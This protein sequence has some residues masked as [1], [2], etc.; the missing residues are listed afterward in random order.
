MGVTGRT[1]RGAETRGAANRHRFMRGS[2]P[3]PS[4]THPSRALPRDPWDPSMRLHAFKRIAV[5]LASA[6]TIASCDD[7]GL[8]PLP[9]TSIP[10]GS[11]Q[12]FLNTVNDSVL[13]STVSTRIVGVAQERSVADSG[14][15]SVNVDGSYEQRYWLRHFIT[16][17]LDRSETVIDVGTWTTTDSG[18]VFTSTV[19]TRAF[20][21]L[22]VDLSNIRTEEPMVF[23]QD[24]PVTEGRYRRTRP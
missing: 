18:Y 10:L 7:S 9:P 23:Y 14:W 16:N 2:I 22:P 13:G 12:W 24:P 6:A 15:L 8:A 19:R 11:G 1:A 3:G 21:V 5:V 4:T 20:L 17:V